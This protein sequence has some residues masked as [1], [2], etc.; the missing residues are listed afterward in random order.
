MVDSTLD[1]TVG[2]VAQLI[3]DIGYPELE[4]E[5]VTMPASDGEEDEPPLDRRVILVN[6]P[7]GPSFVVLAAEDD[8]YFRVQTSYALWRE[9]ADAISVDQ[10]RDLVPGE[11]RE[12]I[13]EDH[14]VRQ[15]VHPDELEEEEDRLPILAAFKVL[16]DLDEE[17]RKEVTYQLSE[18][19][20]N[21][22]VKHVVDSTAD[23]GSVTGFTAYY[24]IF[25]YESEFG[26]R[27]LNDVIER[28]RMAAHRGELFL[29][30]AF[31]LG[32]DIG[33]T[34][35]GDPSDPTNTDRD[36][37]PSTLGEDVTIGGNER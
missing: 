11:L 22:E 10:A 20:T 30:Y 31:N 21:A 19:F 36:A 37:H 28:V 35:A 16:D 4:V 2:D 17:V 32:V 14:P 24:R 1:E 34:T 29:R 15:T 13:P 18:I 8:R 9:M 25:P 5:D 3:Q 26:I 12:E 7:V 6:V 33:K 27:E 23:D